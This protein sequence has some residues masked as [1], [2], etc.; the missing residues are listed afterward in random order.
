MGLNQMYYT[1]EVGNRPV[2]DVFTKVKHQIGKPDTMP[3]V[4]LAEAA[5]EQMDDIPPIPR[6]SCA[7]G[8]TCSSLRCKHSLTL[9]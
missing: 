7:C 4:G 9:N 8:N 6:Y 3:M 1:W 5:S 2:L